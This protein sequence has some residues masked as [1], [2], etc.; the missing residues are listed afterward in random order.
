[1][2]RRSLLVGIVVLLLC[3]FSAC[4]TDAPPTVDVSLPDNNEEVARFTRN[5]LDITGNC[6]ASTF[7]YEFRSDTIL[8]GYKAGIKSIREKCD[9]EEIDIDIPENCEACR[10]VIPIIQEHTK[11]MME[12]AD[13]IEKANASFNQDLLNEGLE[14][15]WEADIVAKDAD[16]SID[17]IRTDYNLPVVLTR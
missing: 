11:L 12:G 3:F 14:K 2:S 4:T 5:I 1:M 6:Q 8:Y 16:Q 17:I 9:L 10:N 13:L 15:F 7:L